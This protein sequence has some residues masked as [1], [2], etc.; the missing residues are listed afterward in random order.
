MVGLGDLLGGFFNSIAKG[1]SDNGV[2]VVGQ[3]RSASGYEAFRMVGG[4]MLG[5]GDL[6][7]GV[8]HSDAHAASANGS[9]IVGVSSSA[10]GYEAFRWTFGGGMVGLGSLGG[11]SF[12]NA[13]SDDGSVIVGSYL[14]GSGS[15][16]FYW[17]STG[18][19]VDLRELLVNNYGLDLTD[20]SL[21]H[22]YGVSASGLTIVGRGINPSGNIEAWRAVITEGTGVEENRSPMFASFELAQNYPNPFESS[23]TIRFALPRSGYT[24]LQIYD[25]T[26][27]LVETLVNETQKPG[28]YGVQWERKNIPSGIYFYRLI[29]G[30]FT[31]T[32]KMIVMR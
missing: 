31:Q 1:V 9:V 29:A 3:G 6:P 4:G 30:D 19:M 8:Y 7:G 27:R 14:S 5:L 23:T 20:W 12:A 11:S 15:K 21:A 18:G 13:V 17:T 26:G 32:R 10:N 22:A 16:A 24:S 2:V 28:V 25:I